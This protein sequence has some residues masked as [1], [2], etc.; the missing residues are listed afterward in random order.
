[1]KSRAVYLITLAAALVAGC[2]LTRF[3]V[4]P[5]QP[6]SSSQQ[7]RQVAQQSQKMPPTLVPALAATLGRREKTYHFTKAPGGIYNADTPS[8]QFTA[9]FGETGVSVQPWAHTHPVELRLTQIGYG[10]QLAPVAQAAVQA[11]ANRIEYRRGTV[12]EWYVNSPLGLE[13][14]FTL[15]SPPAGGDGIKPL[16]LAMQVAGE[17]SMALA[18]ESQSV[19]WRDAN[20]KHVLRYGGLHAYDARG[21]VLKSG[22]Q[23]MQGGIAIE[24][25][26]HGAQYPIVIDPFIETDNFT[27]SDG[28]EHYRFGDTVALDGNR[29]L[30][31]AVGDFEQPDGIIGSAYIF[32]RNGNGVWVEIQ[33]LNADDL[34]DDGSFGWDVAL[35]G[36]TAMVGTFGANPAV[37]KPGQGAVYVFERN[38]QGVWEQVQKLTASPAEKHATF[39]DNIDLEGNR[40]LIGAT[41]AFTD[42][43]TEDEPDQDDDADNIDNDMQGAA[44]I[45]ERNAQGV[46]EQKQKLIASDGDSGDFFGR[47]VLDGDRAFI[48]SSTK[49]NADGIVYVFE[50]NGGGVWVEVQKL[51]V[52]DGRRFG[53]SMAL[54]GNRALI[55]AIWYDNERGAVYIFE[56]N[57]QGVWVEGPKL[58]ASDGV[59]N[60][61]FGWSVDLAGD[62]AFVGTS[63]FG[64]GKA[65]IFERNAQGEWQEVQLLTP[66]GTESQDF[67]GS[68]LDYDAGRLLLGSPGDTIDDEFARGSVYVFDLDTDDD[69]EPDTTDPD[70]DNDGEPDDSDNCPLVANPDQTD[71]DG[72]GLGD[73]CDPDDDDDN[74]PDDIDTCPNDPQ[75]DSD[76]DT[77]CGD[78]DN[79]PVNANTDQ[80]NADNDAFGNVCDLCTDTDTDGFGNPGFPANTC[81][82]DNCPLIANADQLDTDADGQGNVC[83]TDDDN[84]G[85]LDGVDNCPINANPDQKD[86]DED[87]IGNV[88]DPIVNCLGKV[89]TVVGTEGNDLIMVPLLGTQVVQGL[90][91][92]DLIIGTLANKATICGAAGKDSLSGGF[93]NDALDGGS[94]IDTCDGSFGTDTAVNCETKKNV[95]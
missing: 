2:G 82:L 8:K 30:V 89:A 88:C 90:G 5:Q 17:F 87:G 93:G 74:I 86:S 57:A 47:G 43:N 28:V 14:G 16:R 73:A 85:V 45:F 50:R 63:H 36:D 68:S 75:N 35:D 72:D 94:G 19:V 32:E 15:N 4:Q 66:S 24:V 42:E 77:V 38:A 62:Q 40:A 21:K 83:D 3:G 78:V 26:D 23:L 20:G 56:R 12:V 46:W 58:T 25:A 59:E 41:N 52:A 95:P 10:D 91:G 29:A 27:A 55:G 37:V 34:T 81:P 7:A 22:L 9:R 44:Y 54:E 79:C 67:F 60:D 13:Q 61:S 71:A 31:G 11:E 49:N 33:K 39:G 1:M 69:G 6:A 65:Y 80:A 64:P 70:D 18:A 92:D 76:G 53:F 51:T 84:D 48:G